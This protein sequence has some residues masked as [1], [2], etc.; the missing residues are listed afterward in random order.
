MFQGAESEAGRGGSSPV[1]LRS[2]ALRQAQPS[3]RSR[4]GGPHA[5]CACRAAQ[6]PGAEPGSAE[7]AA[8]SSR[9]HRM[10]SN[11]FG[12]TEE[13]QHIP[14]RTNPPG[15][16]TYEGVAGTA[17]TQAGRG[18]AGQRCPAVPTGGKGSGIFEDS[19]PLQTRQRLNPPGG[20]TS[21]IF[22][23]PVAATAPLAHP[24]K[25]K[26]HI[27]MCEGAD[28][29]PGLDGEPCPRPEAKGRSPCRSSGEGSETGPAAQERPPAGLEQGLRQLLSRPGRGAG[30][31]PPTQP[32]SL[33][34]AAAGA[35][36]REEQVEEGR[37]GD[38]M[39]RHE[40][41]LGPRP[42]SH[43]KVL[44]PPGGKSSIS[45]Y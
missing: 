41:R 8:A 5:H 3:I 14:R 9:P 36:P 39:D 23:A 31:L 26:D 37:P 45:F 38:T 42:R 35:A 34:A 18:A 40:P 28:P 11:I 16:A 4:C 6:S 22:G 33:S 2:V 19:T 29:K 20:K 25:P 17:G 7:G 27:F 32:A 15:T 10:A 13:P 12:P 24:N 30:F 44:N 1:S 43:N 21:D